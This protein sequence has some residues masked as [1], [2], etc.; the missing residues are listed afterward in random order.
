MC[1]TC[2]TIF[3]LGCFCVCHSGCSLS[4]TAAT[5]AFVPPSP[6]TYKVKA[7]AADSS[8][9]RMSYNYKELEEDAQFAQAAMLSEVFWMNRGQD[10]QVPIVWLHATS[11]NVLEGGK[12]LVLLHCHAN[13]T[14]MGVMMGSYLELSRFL[15]MDVVAFEYSGYGA[16][17]GKLKT[18]NIYGDALAAYDFVIQRGIDPSR[19]VVFGHCI[20]SAPAVNLASVRPVG[21]LVLHCPIATG[22]NTI[23]PNPGGCCSLARVL[24]CLDVFRNDWRIGRVTCPVLLMHG[25]RDEVV[26]F[27]NAQILRKRCRKAAFCQTYFPVNAGHNTFV[28]SNRQ[29]Y[30]KELATFFSAVRSR[31]TA[32]SGTVEKPLQVSMGGAAAEF[33]VPE[34]KTKFGP[35]IGPDD[36]R[37]KKLAQG[38]AGA[39]DLQGN[40][41]TGIVVIGNQDMKH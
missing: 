2:R 34:A 30:F 18:A 4:K 8:R 38:Q 41:G 6:P 27:H 36:G 31:L 11:D 15:G 16:S 9:S 35:L 3:G 21:G 5:L 40:C 13:A 22:L 19:I 24:C 23:D 25:E 17:V 10:C 39:R 26:P 7:D 1:D 29:A 14:D 28:E 32:G 20:G 12:P 33:E 37:Y